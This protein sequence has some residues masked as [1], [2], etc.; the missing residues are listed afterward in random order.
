MLEYGDSLDIAS[1][2]IDLLYA[3][4]GYRECVNETKIKKPRDESE[5]RRGKMLTGLIYL[6]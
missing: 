4:R 2:Q 5:K 1:L 6:N 3:N